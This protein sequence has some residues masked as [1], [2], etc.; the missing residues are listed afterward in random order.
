MSETTNLLLPLLV[1]AQAQKH[2][3]VNETIQKLDHLVQ[4]AVISR[5]FSAPP[6]N[7]DDGDRYIVASGASGAWGGQDDRL[8]AWQDGVWVFHAPRQGWKI[9]VVSEGI[10]LTYASGRWRAG[11]AMHASGAATFMD[12]VSETHTLAAAAISDTSMVIPERALLLGVTCLVTA[13]VLG[14]PTF[15]VGVDG[16]PQRFGNGIGTGINA[17]LN[18]PLTPA[19]Y[20]SDTPIRLSADG[21]GF[22]GGTVQV[23]AHILKLQIPDFV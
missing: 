16:D 2:V 23:S 10:T 15:S 3:T 4:P 18:A 7:P 8:A 6:A 1:A 9:F 22:A 11:A 21:A 19:A 17:Q 14:P 12:I 5:S 20:Y 13:T